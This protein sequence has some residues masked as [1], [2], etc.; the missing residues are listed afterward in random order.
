MRPQDF[1]ASI[2]L[3]RTPRW[4][5]DHLIAAHDRIDALEAALKAALEG[6]AER[7][8]MLKKLADQIEVIEQWLMRQAEANAA[9]ADMDKE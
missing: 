5:A 6:T 8:N 3:D 1:I 2:E 4:V 9:A 7:T